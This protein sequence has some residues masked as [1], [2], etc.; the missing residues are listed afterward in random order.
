MRGGL[1]RGE[2]GCLR[3]RAR[4][5][6]VGNAL[7]AF[8]DPR[9]GRDQHRAEQRGV[10]GKLGLDQH[11][12]SELAI[13]DMRLDPALADVIVARGRLVLTVKAAARRRRTQRQEA[14]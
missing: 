4:T 11:G 3:V 9:C 14:S 5:L 2:G 6:Q 7:V 1:R 10:I 12:L 8:S 13:G